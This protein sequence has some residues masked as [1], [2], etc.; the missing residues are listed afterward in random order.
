[1]VARLLADP[2][3]DA[4]LIGSF[5]DYDQDSPDSEYE[6]HIVL[7][8]PWVERRADGVRQGYLPISP[9]TL[10][11]SS[12]PRAYREWQ[13][14]VDGVRGKTTGGGAPGLWSYDREAGANPRLARLR[15]GL[16]YVRRDASFMAGWMA[17]HGHTLGDRANRVYSL[18][19]LQG[20]RR[21]SIANKMG[22][23]PRTVDSFLHRMRAQAGSPALEDKPMRMGALVPNGTHLVMQRGL[24]L[25]PLVARA[26]GSIQGYG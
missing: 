16:A 4:E 8:A 23:L 22:V 14:L 6:R 21:R 9:R 12:F 13:E 3:D 10:Q 1:M 7:S 25:Q 11:P 24:P 19:F 20:Y 15:A 26:T 2:L 17:R 18:F 5:G